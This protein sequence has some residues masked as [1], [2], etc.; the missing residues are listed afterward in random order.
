MQLILTDPY[1]GKQ[2]ANWQANEFQGLT[3]SSEVP[4]GMMTASFTVPA[5]FKLPYKWAGHFNQVWIYH[6]YTRVWK[7]FTYGLERYWSENDSGIKVDAIGTVAFLNARSTTVNL[8]AEKGSAYITD[9]I[10]TDGVVSQWLSTGTIDT[11]DYTMPTR[12]Y[13]PQKMFR[14]ILDDIAAF[15]ANTYDWYVWDDKFYFVPRETVPTY[16]TT[17]EYCTGSVRQDLAEFTNYLTY[18]Y[19]TTAGVI[20]RAQLTDSDSPYPGYEKIEAYS[21]QMTAAQALQ[22]ATESLANRKVL[23]TTAPITVQKCWYSDGREVHPSEIMPGKLLRVEGLIPAAASI[24][25]AFTD[26]DIDTF[27]IIGTT[28]NHDSQTAQINPG[29]IGQTLP[30]L[31]TRMGK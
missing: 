11:N 12:D 20:T 8:T 30:V 26:N 22:I 25:E 18:S 3:F 17:T 6:D 24:A 15:N 14:E 7:G 5:K 1:G 21:D 16:Y 13:S 2:Y 23:G 4:G 29:R 10:L 27:R 9:H 28:Y 19:S 31:L